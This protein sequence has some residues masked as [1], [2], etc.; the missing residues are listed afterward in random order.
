MHKEVNL[1]LVSVIIAAFNTERYIDAALTSAINQDYENIEIIV[2][3]DGS[4]DNTRKLLEHYLPKIAIIDQPNSGV[5]HARNAAIKY[6]SGTYI[7]FLDSDDIW[8]PTKIS[9]QINQLGELN[10]AY[11]D[12]AYI[13]EKQ[14]GL[15]KRSDLSKLYS[16]SIFQHLL[17]ENF[18]TTSSVLIK[19]ELLL[20]FGCFDENMKVLEDWKLWLA[21]A[22]KHE[23]SLVSEALVKY[24]VYPMSTSRKAREVLPYH[25][26]LLKET[27]NHLPDS[28]SNKQL[29]VRAV[30][31]SYNICSY[32][33]EDGSD[34]QFSLYCAAKAMTLQPSFSQFKRLVRTLLNVVTK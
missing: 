12:A 4:T 26:K 28:K 33:S 25:L 34:F 7:A 31:N 32:I 21:I 10:W 15:E 22:K 16:G 17:T 1:P 14:T 24:R 3:N 20:E 11:T 30:R 8:E 29:K 2:V 6:S 19:K 9:K 23:I 5:A 27:F 13:G 18:I